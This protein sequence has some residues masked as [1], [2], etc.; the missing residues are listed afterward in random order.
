[1]KCADM[2]H[3]L[4][5]SLDTG[6]WREET[7]SDQRPASRLHYTTTENDVNEEYYS[8]DQVYRN[9]V[10][11]DV[12]SIC[13][14][15][16]GRRRTRAQMTEEDDNDEEAPPRK[17]QHLDEEDDDYEVFELS[18][19]ERSSSRSSSL[20]PTLELIQIAD[21]PSSSE[22]FWWIRRMRDQMTEEDD[23]NE[24]APSSTR[25]HLEEE[26]ND[27][28]VFELTI[29]ERSSSRSWSL[30][31]TL[32]FIPPVDTL[33]SIELSWWMIR[34]EYLDSDEDTAVYE[35]MPHPNVVFGVLYV[36]LVYLRLSI[37]ILDLARTVSISIPFLAIINY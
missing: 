30:S 22:Y 16:K 15:F 24:D 29:L 2:S 3:C 18:I 5:I 13:D 11:E 33:S 31:S 25:Q 7:L 14:H 17:R 35:S 32:E 28:E 23:N 4:F 36:L 20:S 26:E 27:Y 1:M 8:L 21:T 6:T 34:R 12:H 9:V 37:I 19:L 10:L